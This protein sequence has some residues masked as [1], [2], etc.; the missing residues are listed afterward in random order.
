M[1]FDSLKSKTVSELYNLLESLKKEQLSQRIQMRLG[2]EGF[3]SH[4]MKEVRRDLA[5]IK[6]KLMQ[7]KLGKGG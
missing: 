4:K 2:T 3:K 1:N 5:R 6:T 7:M